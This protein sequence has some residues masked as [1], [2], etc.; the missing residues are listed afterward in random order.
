MIGIEWL[1][2]NNA[3]WMFK[4]G[5]IRINGRTY[6]L[7]ERKQRDVWVQRVTLVRATTVIRLASVMEQDEDEEDEEEE[8]VV[9]S[10]LTELEHLESKDCWTDEETVPVTTKEKAEIDGVS[11]DMCSEW[12]RACLQHAQQ[13]DESLSVVY[14]ALETSSS[15]P[16]KR[17]R[18]EWPALAKILGT[19]WDRLRLHDGILQSQW[20]N[21]DG[22]S[23]SYPVIMPEKYRQGE[24]WKRHVDENGKHRNCAEMLRAMESEVYWPGRGNDIHAWIKECQSCIDS[25][26]RPGRPAKPPDQSAAK[27]SVA[28]QTPYLWLSATVTETYPPLGADCVPTM[29]F[30]Q[31]FCLGLPTTPVP[32]QDVP[33]P[34][35]DERILRDRGRM[36][37]PSRFRE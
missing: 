11:Q 9:A 34:D 2:A 33:Q 29:T 32:Q 10:G 19:Q 7:S 36:R 4:R 27:R 18:S 35:M 22:Q 17:E 37:R 12:A 28:V 1:E 13:T 26:S 30:H 24:F 5:A 20:K 14:R 6:K 23:F 8:T 31:T 25:K 16:S 15:R 21:A 3:F